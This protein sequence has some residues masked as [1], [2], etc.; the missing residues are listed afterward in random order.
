M[1]VVINADTNNEI[2]VDNMQSIMQ[3]TQ[4]KATYALLSFGGTIS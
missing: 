1:R 2:S 4:S 3:Q